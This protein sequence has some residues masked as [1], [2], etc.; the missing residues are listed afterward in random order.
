MFQSIH[1]YCRKHSIELHWAS[2]YRMYC[3][4]EALIQP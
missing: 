4:A 1:E 2:A 3:A